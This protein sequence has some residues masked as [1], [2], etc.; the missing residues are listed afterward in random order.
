MKKI[1]VFVALLGGNLL[2]KPY[3]QQD[4]A[5]LVSPEGFHFDRA[6]EM[7]KTLHPLAGGAITH[8]DSDADRERARRD[9]Q[10][11]AEMLERVRDDN[12]IGPDQPERP[13]LLWLLAQLGVY[14]HNLGLE[15]GRARARSNFEAVRKRP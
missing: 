2:A 12:I 1:L 6:I 4:L 3:P 14:G 5:A 10:L 11:L 8:F 9:I 7:V 13:Q 15:D